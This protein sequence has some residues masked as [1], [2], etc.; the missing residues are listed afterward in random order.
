MGDLLNARTRQLPAGDEPL[1]AAS[2]LLTGAMRETY[3]IQYKGWQDELWTYTNTVGEF[4]SVIDWFSAGFSRM[5]LRAAI[6][7]PGALEPTILETGPFA[8]KVA[9]I[10]TNA[11]GGETAF[12]RNWGKHLAVPGVGYFVAKEDPK[13]GLRTYDVKSADVM[14]RS[15][16]QFDRRDEP[17]GEKLS[18]F[19]IQ[20]SPD[21]WE[22]L[23]PNFSFVTRIYDPDPRHDYYPT[24]MTKG[25]LTTLREI[26]LYNRA[27]I[28]T[29]MSR[30]AFNGILF[31]PSE[32]TLPVNKQFKD[33]PD[34]FI[35]ELVAVASRGIK[36][37]GSPGA[38]IP[39]PLR[40]PGDKIEQFKHLILS[41]GLDPKII[42]ARKSAVER[43]AEQLPAPPE[44]MTG[45]SDMNHWNAA[46]Q[47][48]D[49][50][51]LYFAP[52]MELLCGGMTQNVVRPMLA[53]EGVN[54]KTDEMRR[55]VVWYDAS[56][57]T[58]DADNSTNAEMA[59]DR[60]VIKEESLRA[61]TGFD[62][63]D[64]P[65]DEEKRVQ[66]LT[67]LAAK[68]VPLPDSYFLLYP[69][70]FEQAKKFAPV[71]PTPA[72]GADGANVG[73]S[74]SSAPAPGK[75]VKEPV[76]NKKPTK[77]QTGPQA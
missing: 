31:I 53:A 67:G 30:I 36:D 72:L 61:S 60:I 8:E 27:I 52:P 33:A 57:L 7:E 32:V 1:T 23:D 76:D 58:K 46:S 18:T 13:T 74:A 45:I 42:D 62:E 4:G 70:D 54:M 44:A 37:P 38:A 71:P 14:R 64:A 75:A 49:N 41:T 17:N 66:I 48:E 21:Q 11:N 10:V 63:D 50:V 56:D 55:T 65:S 68:G 19:D 15:A 73:P 16:R 29:L 25:A 39:L 22:T 59:F 77:Q 24:S 51:K 47:S 3:A 2:Q 43:L 69:Q 26:D 5:H 28:A 9:D 20:I 12:L 6:W 40:V 34:P 35:A